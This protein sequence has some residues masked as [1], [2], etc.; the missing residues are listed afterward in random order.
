MDINI[1]N[2]PGK[3][4]GLNDATKKILTH[5]ALIISSNFR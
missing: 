3:R 1:F 5:I 2:T 4:C